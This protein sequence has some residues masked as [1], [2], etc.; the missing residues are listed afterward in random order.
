MV[1]YQHEQ[2]ILQQSPSSIEQENNRRRSITRIIKSGSYQN[3]NQNIRHFSVSS[4]LNKK[5]APAQPSANSAATTSSSL[6]FQQPRINH[7]PQDNDAQS[8][9][10][11]KILFR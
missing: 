2:P 10:L 9:R 11:V 8:N 1:H 6:E 5:P 4:I 7:G 3:I